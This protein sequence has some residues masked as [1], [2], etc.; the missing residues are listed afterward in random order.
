M[1]EP[2]ALS[3]SPPDASSC[4]RGLVITG[5]SWN[6]DNLPAVPRLS[7]TVTQ[8]TQ[9]KMRMANV[10]SGWNS[11]K[12]QLL[13]A[14]FV[15]WRSSTVNF[16]LFLSVKIKTRRTAC[17]ERGQSEPLQSRE[18]LGGAGNKWFNCHQAAL[19][20][21]IS[22]CCYNWIDTFLRTESLLCTGPCRSC[23][24]NSKQ[25]LIPS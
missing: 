12:G 4:T 9:K 6:G 16:I 5:T 14:L 18:E 11:R 1:T 10:H 22:Y 13:M 25:G 24:H 8:R 21:D 23:N 2:L 20:E 17:W 3:L 19:F 7:S 15:T